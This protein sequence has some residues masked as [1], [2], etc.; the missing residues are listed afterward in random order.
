MVW[1]SEC[2]FCP[3]SLTCALGGLCV[4]PKHL[5]QDRTA[6][7]SRSQWSSYIMLGSASVPDWTVCF[8]I[9]VPAPSC[10][11]HVVVILLQLSLPRLYWRS[12]F[13]TKYEM[14]DHGFRCSCR[15]LFNISGSG[16]GRGRLLLVLLLKR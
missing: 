7:D 10:D 11:S 1:F 15:D 3:V 2:I 14:L 9:A 8:V 12:L 16:F 4:P 6:W 5:V 13:T